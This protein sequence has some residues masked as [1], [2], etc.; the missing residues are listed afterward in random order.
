MMGQSLC[1]T[2]AALKR[3]TRIFDHAAT[4]IVAAILA[5]SSPVLSLAMPPIYATRFASQP[6]QNHFK[7]LRV[8]SQSTSFGFNVQFFFAKS[9]AASGAW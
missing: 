6:D 5:G 8:R 7:G 4:A 1:K 9:T 2:E 3:D